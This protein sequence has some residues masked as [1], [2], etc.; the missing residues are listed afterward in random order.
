MTGPLA[1]K[2]GQR[3]HRSGESKEKEK[4]RPESRPLAYAVDDPYAAPHGPSPRAPRQR[5]PQSSPR[6][7]RT[8]ACPLAWRARSPRHTAQGL[9][10]RRPAVDRDCPVADHDAIGSLCGASRIEIMRQYS[11]VTSSR[12]ARCCSDISLEYAR[13]SDKMAQSRRYWHAASLTRAVYLSRGV[14]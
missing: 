5:A 13:T 3:P 7:S 6:S 11:P 8:P 2:T 12:M 10:E 14:G 1:R 9:G 4:G